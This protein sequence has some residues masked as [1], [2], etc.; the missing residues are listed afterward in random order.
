MSGYARNAIVHAGRLD[1]G[2]NYLAKPF[3]PEPL[4]RKVRSDGGRLGVDGF[5]GVRLHEG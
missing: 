4:A 5:H 1:E 2:V 3:T